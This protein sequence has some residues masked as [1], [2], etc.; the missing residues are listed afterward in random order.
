LLNKTKW[1][2]KYFIYLILIL[3]VIISLY[4]IFIKKPSEPQFKKEGE[5]T[6]YK[7][8]NRHFVKKVDI[9]V[10][11]N[12][13]ERMQGLMYRTKMDE[14]NGML[15]IF[16]YPD[17]KS[18][19]MKNT[20]LPLDIMFIDSIGVI[21]TIYRHTTPYSEKLVWSRKKVQFVVEM[22]TGW[23]DKNGV[24][25]GDLIEFKVDGK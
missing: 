2:G 15:F 14:D 12:Y 9:E 22:N 4:F 19:W 13:D 18:F 7:I 3:A 17:I 8:L 25:E 16:E 1:D 24:N 5:V 21:D 6:F 11:N 10:A 20:I 23:S